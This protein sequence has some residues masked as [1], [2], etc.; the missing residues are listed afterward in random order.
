[1]SQQEALDFIV[2][3]GGPPGIDWPV[4]A[5]YAGMILAALLI[6]VTSKKAG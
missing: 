4:V 2:E 5:V 3:T 1:M 6:F